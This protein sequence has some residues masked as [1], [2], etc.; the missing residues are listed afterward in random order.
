MLVAKCLKRRLACCI[1]VK[2]VAWSKKPIYTQNLNA[3]IL[4][5]APYCWLNPFSCDF[6]KNSNGL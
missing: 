1:A 4:V 2:I 3:F 6:T 5:C